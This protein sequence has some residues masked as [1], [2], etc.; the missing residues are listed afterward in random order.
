M[1]EHLRVLRHGPE[2]KP[3]EAKV[4]GTEELR[5]LGKEVTQAVFREL[6]PATGESNPRGY[7]LDRVFVRH[8]N[9]NGD[10]GGFVES[11]ATVDG[12]AYLG[13]KALVLDQAKVLEH[14]VVF[15][16]ATIEHGALVKGNAKVQGKARISGS[17][18]VS[19]SADIRDDV[20]V[21]DN[22]R[23]WGNAHLYKNAKL[24]SNAEAKD[25]CQIAED[26]ILGADM[27]VGGHVHVYN[28]QLEQLTLEG[29]IWI[30]SPKDGEPLIWKEGITIVPADAW[31][32]KGFT[33]PTVSERRP[34]TEW[35]IGGEDH[36]ASPE[37]I[38]EYLTKT[39][40]LSLAPGKVDL[41][42]KRKD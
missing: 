11:S 9:R 39:K 21:G 30:Y 27:T 42:S 31:V 33:W 8:V 41:P 2:A 6:H 29:N 10:L 32:K 35:L 13:S 38:L 37:A 16:T 25:N 4:A 3:G 22:A 7:Y 24:K 34:W 19:N 28:A 23:V 1:A 5:S 15:G 20:E 26:V 14:S 40:Q 18:F 12:T 17:A 36:L